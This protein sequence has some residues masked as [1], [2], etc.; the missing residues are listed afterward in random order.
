MLTSLIFIL[1][2]EAAKPA[3]KLPFDLNYVWGLLGILILAICAGLIVMS[4]TREEVQITEGKRADANEKLVKTRDVELSDC[5]KD[6][7][8]CQKDLERL[9]L[10][11]KTVVGIKIE[12]L[13][14]HWNNKIEFEARF[15]NVENENRKLLRRLEK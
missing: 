7:V 11:Y 5:Q 3:D 15:E 14:K 12:E 1:A 6:L 2:E 8:E 9:K 13:V 4:K 10:E